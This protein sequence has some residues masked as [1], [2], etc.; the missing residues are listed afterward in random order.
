M[1]AERGMATFSERTGLKPMKTILQ[2]DSMDDALRNRLWNVLIESVWNQSADKYWSGSAGDGFFQRLWH[3]HYREPMDKR[4]HDYYSAI[5]EVRNRY[6][7]WEW[8]EVYDFIE[9]VARNRPPSSQDKFVRSCNYILEKELSAYRFV[10]QTL[11][12]ITS[13]QELEAVKNALELKDVLKP[14]RVHIAAAVKLFADR[15]APDYRNS[16]KESVSAV[17]AVCG[18]IVGSSATLGQALKKLEDKGVPLHTALKSS[19]SSLHGYT[20]N[21]DGIRHALLDESALDFD[22]AKFMLVSCS[23]FVNYLAAK[24]SKAGVIRASK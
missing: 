21:A 14:V 24:A 10:A 22:D 7:A 13:D 18:I 11:V 4:Q 1:T 16:I 20:S 2:K 8:N 15:K 6:F 3:F 17:E 19:F 5:T 12:P 9:F 23:G